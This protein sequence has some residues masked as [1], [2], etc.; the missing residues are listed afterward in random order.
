MTEQGTPVS[1]L[2]PNWL[3]LRIAPDDSSV[4]NDLAWLLATSPLDAIRDGNEAVRLASRARELTH[5]KTPAV[6]DTLGAA[7]A[8]TGRF[9]RAVDVTREAVRVLNAVANQYGHE[10]E[11]PEHLIGGCAIDATGSALPPESLA[12]TTRFDVTLE[13]VALAGVPVIVPV[14]ELRLKPDGN[15]EPVAGDQ[16]QV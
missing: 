13:E 15:A 8:E 5:G 6:L 16:L 4:I 2:R 1:A 7:Y 11:F 12:V 10:F 3:V 14:V 9:G